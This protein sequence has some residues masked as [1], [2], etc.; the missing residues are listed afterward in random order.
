MDS[1]YV[2]DPEAVANA[3]IVRAL[4]RTQIPGTK[5]RNDPGERDGKGAGVAISTRVE[6]RS[7]RPA[8]GARSFRLT[9][10]RRSRDADHRLDPRPLAPT[11]PT[12]A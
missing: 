5:F 7:F 12:R 8:R 4:A 6:V 9:A 10:P 2:V 3:I 1:N 11:A